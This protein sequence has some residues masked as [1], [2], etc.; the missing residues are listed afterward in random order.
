MNISCNLVKIVLELCEQATVSKQE[1]EE[2]QDSESQ[3]EESD[4]EQAQVQIEEVEQL[5]DL[6]VTTP[7]SELSEMN[8]IAKS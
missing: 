4:E 8:A 3:D 2:E 7:N 1:S 5:E 6:Q